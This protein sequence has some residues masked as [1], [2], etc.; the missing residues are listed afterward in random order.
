VVV[1]QRGRDFSAV[2]EKGGQSVNAELDNIY[3]LLNRQT[4]SVTAATDKTGSPPESVVPKASKIF[5]IGSPDDPARI[6]NTAQDA[7]SIGEIL[8]F[9]GGIVARAIA[10]DATFVIPIFVN[11]TVATAFGTILPIYVGRTELIVEST[12]IVPAVGDPVYLSASVAGRATNA[13]PAGPDR[14]V[15]LGMWTGTTNPTTGRAEAIVNM[16]IDVGQGL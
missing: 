12:S 1:S 11:T 13:A 7:F 2:L 8:G 5:S 9:S 3:R 16:K 14:S 15:L 10:A 4:Q 6:R